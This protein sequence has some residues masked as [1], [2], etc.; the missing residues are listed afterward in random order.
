[1]K[2]VEGRL[3]DC[4]QSKDRAAAQINNDCGPLSGSSNQFQDRT[5]GENPAAGLHHRL[6]RSMI[7]Y[8]L[9]GYF[10]RDHV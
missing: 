6:D 7:G 2:Y 3:H 8:F 10:P 4:L 1:M 9:A 5:I